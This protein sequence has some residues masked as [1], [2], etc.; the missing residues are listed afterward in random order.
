METPTPTPLNISELLIKILAHVDTLA[1]LRCQRVSRFWAG[2]IEHSPILQ[3]ALF[4]RPCER[5]HD[6]MSNMTCNPFIFDIFLSLLNEQPNP[7]AWR[8][9]LV[10]PE[11]NTSVFLRPE[12]SWRRMFTQQ[13]PAEEM[14]LEMRMLAR[15]WRQT[16]PG[17]RGQV[18]IG[19]LGDLLRIEQMERGL[20]VPEASSAGDHHDADGEENKGLRMGV[21]FDF[22]MLM[23]DPNVRCLEMTSV[24]PEGK[25]YGRLEGTF[26]A[27]EG[28]G[29]VSITFITR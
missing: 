15:Y 25:G 24:Q 6:A 14:T 8:P 12:A 26:S 11:R 1:L 4:F 21:L 10:H 18:H 9:S 13:P 7:E 22:I 29:E 27:T 23:S 17:W 19:S 5:T 3:R 16:I 20:A 2:V 28:W